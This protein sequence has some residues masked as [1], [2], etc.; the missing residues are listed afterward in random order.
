MNGITKEILA[1]RLKLYH[2]HQMLKYGGDAQKD[3]S[4]MRKL[5]IGHFLNEDVHIV[6]G[7]K[8]LKAS[9]ISKHGVFQM[10]VANY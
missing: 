9:M 10:A 1:L 5:G 2:T 7:A 8:L 3:T 6:Q 4:M